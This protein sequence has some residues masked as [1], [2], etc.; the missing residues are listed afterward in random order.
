MFKVTDGYGFCDRCEKEKDLIIIDSSSGAIG[1]C[2]E[3][4]FPTMN[5]M[6]TIA[7]YLNLGGRESEKRK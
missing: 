4:Y 6:Q 7:K 5:E 3:C 1:I 2:L